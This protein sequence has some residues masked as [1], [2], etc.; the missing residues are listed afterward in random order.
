MAI[1]IFLFVFQSF[2]FQVD[3]SEE[4]GIVDEVI[5]LYKAGLSQELIFQYIQSY[6]KSYQVSAE[7]VLKM[8]ENN[9][10]EEIIKKVLQ[11]QS[12]VTQ[13][14]RE[15]K[16]PEFKNLLLKK[17]FMKKNRLGN[18][19]LKED[20]VEWYD[21]KEP[22]ENFSF[23]IKGI[24]TIYLNCKPR[25]EENFCYEIVFVNF[26]KKEYS[27]SDFNWEKGENKTINELYKFF[28][29]NYKEIIYQEKVK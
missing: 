29:E 16:E 13:K 3:I 14:E 24:K 19:A 22:K 20:R 9:V 1:F 27:F 17:G 28:K 2:L 25:T 26:D 6:K 15:K 11:Y 18:L 12:F 8:K 21:S 23:K 4:K 5:K 10:P 7:D